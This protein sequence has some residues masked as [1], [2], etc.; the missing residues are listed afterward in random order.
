MQVR[1]DARHEPQTLQIKWSG[2]PIEPGRR[3]FVAARGEEL[4]LKLE[5]DAI[6]AILDPQSIVSDWH[7]SGQGFL[8]FRA[9][10]EPGHRTV[11]ARVVK[12]EQ[13]W[14]WPIEIELRESLEV[15]PAPDA[16]P[17]TVSFT[18]RNNSRHG[19]ARDV[20]IHAAGESTRLRLDLKPQATGTFTVPAP[21]PGSH[22]IEVRSGDRLF[23]RGRVT[24]WL[25][26][27]PDTV[28]LEPVEVPFN[29]HLTQIFRN[30]YL[31]PRPQSVSLSVPRQGIGSWCK[32]A[33]QF[34]VDDAGLRA[35]ARET[36]MLALPNGVGFATPSD[37]RARNIA[38]VS[39]WSNYPK[40]IEVP[41]GGRASHL[42]LLMAGS[43]QSMQSRIDNG[44]IVVTY[45]DGST[46]RLAL[47]NPET[48]WP[49]D[50]DYA[51]DDFAFRL[52]TVPPRIDLKTGTIRIR[53][54]A[55]AR[56]KGR[57]VDGGAATVLDLPLD[58]SKQ[59]RS[60]TLRA[61]ANEVV[62]GLMGI[63]LVRD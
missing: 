4:R 7:A 30:D 45:T 18:L 20:E 2:K 29:D 56:G 48:W 58:R 40:T 19:I 49:I 23:A 36:G 9:A 63:T 59:L 50:Q 61:V 15:L 26:P 32:P 37:P 16:A 55:D 60:I 33:R 8:R 6:E 34:E 52:G 31:S 22:A 62:L 11:F 13:K 25:T 47:R 24:Q 28:R 14:I 17:G 42:Y 5:V 57:T 3:E 10:G 12:G 21:L 43:T 35:L 27:L 1:F 41:L 46:D 39:Q 51:I 38:F 53:T 54:L 44:E